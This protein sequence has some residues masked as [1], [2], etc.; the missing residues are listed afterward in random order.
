MRGL[1]MPFLRYV[2]LFYIVMEEG[3]ESRLLRRGVRGRKLR[4]RREETR[5]T[6]WRRF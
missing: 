6:I 3:A 2:F 4:A 1:G 5:N